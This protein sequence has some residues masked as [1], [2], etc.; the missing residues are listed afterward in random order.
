VQRGQLF[1][2]PLSQRARVHYIREFLDWA[3]T[4]GRTSEWIEAAFWDC[5]LRAAPDEM[6]EMFRAKRK[7][8]RRATAEWN[9]LAMPA[10]ARDGFESFVE[11]REPKLG[12]SPANVP[13]A[14]NA[15]TGPDGKRYL[16]YGPQALVALNETDILR[17]ALDEALCDLRGLAAEA[18]GR[19]E[20][21]R[22]YFVRMRAARKRFCSARCTWQ[23]L[24]ARRKKHVP[25][26]RVTSKTMAKR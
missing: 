26:E 12:L 5:F 20:Q 25:R 2:T 21:C 14:L 17:A 9:W 19:C 10:I 16:H 23:A 15:W 24:Q 22:R 6:R 4:T 8:T 3:Y 18:L 7:S 13:R 1:K 11:D